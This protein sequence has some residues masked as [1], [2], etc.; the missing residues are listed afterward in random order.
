LLLCFGAD[1]GGF[2]PLG[3][4]RNRPDRPRS[5]REDYGGRGGQGKC[6]DTDRM[7]GKRP[8]LIKKRT[9]LV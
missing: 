9:G 2:A 5:G 1:A 8:P 7:S 3:G 6:G 4:C